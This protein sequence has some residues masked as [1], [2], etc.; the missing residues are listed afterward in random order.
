MTTLN[1]QIF[2]VACSENGAVRTS[3]AVR[4]VIYPVSKWAHEILG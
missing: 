1:L 2:F 3:R 4:R